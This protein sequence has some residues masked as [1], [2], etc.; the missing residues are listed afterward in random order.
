MGAD[1]AGSGGLAG[2]VRRLNDD[3]RG[4]GKA[5]L[6]FVAGAL[7]SVLLWYPLGLPS[8]MV[9][10][11]VAQPNLICRFGS[12]SATDIFGAAVAAGT[13]RMYVCS[14]GVAILTM[15][16]PLILIAL[17]FVYRKALAGLVRLVAVRLP[18]EFRFLVAPVVATLVFAMAWSGSHYQTSGMIG[19]LPQTIFPAVVGV[20]TYAVA[21]WG[22]A[23]QR[24]LAP[25]FDVR[26]RLPMKARVALTV[27]FPIVFAFLL[28]AETRVSLTAQKEQVVVLVGLVT[29]FLMLAPRRGDVLTGVSQQLA[30]VAEQVRSQAEQRAAQVRAARR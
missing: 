24:R 25:F 9:R 22:G 19:F 28:T 6:V 14:W 18:G 29:G 16:G 11:V 20:F 27:V 3:P 1:G 21:R 10:N 17:A 7:L 15:A 4:L 30:T 23:L 26:D 12:T 8:E 13:P 5:V 2:A